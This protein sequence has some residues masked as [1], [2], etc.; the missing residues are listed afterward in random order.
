MGVL[1]NI[2]ILGGMKILWIL[3]LFCLFFLG[4]GG[5]RQNWTSFRCLFCILGSFLSVNV[6]SE[7]ILRGNN[8]K[9]FL[10]CLIFP[11]FSGGKR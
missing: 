2:N 3:F 9:Y 8:F 1:R 5:S 10:G 11:I 6:Q 4:G 7:N